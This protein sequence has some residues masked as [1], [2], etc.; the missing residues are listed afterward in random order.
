MESK[1]TYRAGS[2]NIRSVSEIMDPEQLKR[3]EAVHRGFLYQHLYAVGCLLNL[4]AGDEGEIRVERDEDV[5]VV[6]D[7]EIICIQVKT[8]SRP[9]IRTDI[10]SALERFEN[11][12]KH[13]AQVNPNESLRFVIVSNMSLEPVL[14]EYYAGEDWPQDVSVVS[15]SGVALDC[16]I[17]PPVWQ[18][19][20]HAV[21]WCV[22]AAGKIPFTTL[23]PERPWCGSWLRVCS[24]RPPDKNSIERIMCSIVA[25]CQRYL[26]SSWSNCRNF[27]LF[28]TISG[29]KRMSR[30]LFQGHPS[31]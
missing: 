8:R 17:L 31:G 6:T 25:S 13:F 24:L 2:E 30:F 9:L 10:N 20:D 4:G 1:D 23:R 12:R 18:S 16:I 15:P 28:P 7:D 21:R 27:L 29:H 26:S 14:A 11:L 19:L 22:E 5:E 3:I